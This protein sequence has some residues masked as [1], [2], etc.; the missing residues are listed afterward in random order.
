MERKLKTELA[1]E[2]V[3][4]RVLVR[5]ESGKSMYSLSKM[6]NDWL[7]AINQGNF[8]TISRIL[9]IPAPLTPELERAIRTAWAVL[10]AA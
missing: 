8:S 1:E 7:E 6:I 9:P 3:S 5:P 4:I 10:T 2:N